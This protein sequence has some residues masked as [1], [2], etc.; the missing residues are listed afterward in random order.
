MKGHVGGGPV[1]DNL[2]VSARSAKFKP[3][4]MD[5]LEASASRGAHMSQKRKH[6]SFVIFVQE[7]LPEMPVLLS[8]IPRGFDRTST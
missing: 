4:L 2:W 5:P 1:T 8:L 6:T 3:F 7:R